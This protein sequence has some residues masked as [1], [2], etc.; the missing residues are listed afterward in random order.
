MKLKIYLSIILLFG[1]NNFAISGGNTNSNSGAHPYVGVGFG[2][3][4]SDFSRQDDLG[5]KLFGGYRINKNFAAEVG[6]VNFGD[7]TASRGQDTLYLSVLGIAPINNQFSIFG[8]VGFHSWDDDVT[9]NDGTDIMWGFGVSYKLD[10]KISF[11]LEHE[12]FEDAAINEISLTSIGV[13]IA[14]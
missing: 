9:G 5:L 6:Y 4:D 8:K 7:E 14:F 13:S 12:I 2:S 10:K 1:L 3:V 11:R